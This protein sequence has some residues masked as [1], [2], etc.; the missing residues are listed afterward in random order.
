MSKNYYQILG[1]NK[2]ASHDDIKKAYRTL[3]KKYHPDR[4]GGD[5][6][7][8]KEIN[9]AYSILG[10]EQKRKEYDNPPRSFFDGFDPFSFGHFGNFR[11]MASDI[12][13]LIE[14][15]IED[16]Y[17]GCKKHIRVGMKA[18]N[19]DI[20]KGTKNGQILRVPNMGVKGYDVYGKEAVGDLIVKI[21]VNPNDKMWLNTDGTLETMYTV[22]WID[23]I[24]GNETTIN[25][26]DRVVKFKIPKYT[27]NCGY[28][29]ISKNGFR[30]FKKDN[31]FGNL[32]INFIVKMPS[33]LSDKQ[34]ELL[35]QI[36]KTV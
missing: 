17:F 21:Q 29:I 23:A 12:Q 22:D 33:K 11:Q 4:N 6:S 14:I 27:Q 10:D 16:A 20:P 36:K 7:K 8:F 15:P 18:I 30:L 3:S 32:K 5:D 26:F 19:I 31:E 28:T 25:I 2:S 9:E 24:L 35:H 13:T 1:V 34:I